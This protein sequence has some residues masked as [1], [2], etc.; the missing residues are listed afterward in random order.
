MRSTLT[1]AAVL[2][3]LA[4]PASA[5]GQELRS[6]QSA[7][8]SGSTIDIYNV[9][10]YVTM[11]RGGGSGVTVRPTAQ[12]ADG[13]Q[14]RFFVDRGGSE[15]VFRVQYPD[16][17][18]ELAAPEGRAGRTRFSGRSQVRLRSDG[19]F[20]GD[21]DVP[22]RN[23]G[24]EIAIG[25]GGLRAWADLEV[26]VPANARVRVHLIVGEVT[27]NGVDGDVVIDTWSANAVAENIAGTWL[28]NVGSGDVAV[29]GARGTLRIE[30]GSGTGTVN[31]MR[32][33][34]LEIETGSGDV[35]VSDAQVERCNFDTGS[36][37][38]RVTGLTARRC[39][40]DTGSGSVTLDYS[41]GAIDDLE[42]D[43]GSGSVRLT[44]PPNPNV[45]IVA[46]VGSG[47]IDLQRSGGMLERRNRNE[48]AMRF[49]EGRGRVMIDT[50]SG[51]ITIR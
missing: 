29:R 51:G 40:A 50:G 24:R 16:D 32:G 11:R 15:T 28:F 42:I 49:G 26:E 9:S 2:A 38:V 34:V 23:R 30:A 35:Q 7:S 21:D 13:G 17:M 47:G 5:Q 12:G 8:L 39:V 44:L 46:E 27:V 20:G 10:G 4:I 45:R 22:R 1:T 31:G 25:R 33:D 36:G 19:T 14:L 48:L 18:D 37:D 6:G 43:T 3:A 41:G